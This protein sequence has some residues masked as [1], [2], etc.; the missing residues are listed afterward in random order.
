MI[1]VM[2][3][4]KSFPLLQSNFWSELKITESIQCVLFIFRL[5]HDHS[6]KNS[7]TKK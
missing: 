4:I 2:S 5:L 6:Y 7:R 3:L 1:R